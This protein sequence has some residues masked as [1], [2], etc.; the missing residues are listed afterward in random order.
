M[1]LAFDTETTGFPDTQAPSTAEHQPH[2]VQL[3]FVVLD[4]AGREVSSCD[5]LVRPVGWTIPPRTTEIHGI[6]TD[7]AL[8][9][10]L[11]LAEVVTMYRDAVRWTRARVAHNLAFDDRIMRIAMCRAGVSRDE[12]E[13][14]EARP[15]Y[16]T[17]L[18]AHNHVKAPPTA[19]MLAAG[20]THH[21]APNLGE[22]VRHFFGQEHAGAHNGLADARACG[23]VYHHL[24]GLEL[25]LV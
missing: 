2:L 15:S 1:I 22:C 7:H 16:C 20:R 4:D 9:E 13:A 21:K 24:R 11:P 6:T 5:V 25:A 19:R 10:G 18:L 14:L 8:A 17:K 3:G 12:I 23:R